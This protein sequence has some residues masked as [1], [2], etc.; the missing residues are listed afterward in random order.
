[1]VPVTPARD[2]RPQGVDCSPPGDSPGSPGR[3]AVEAGTLAA[4]VQSGT[5]HLERLHRRALSA[6]ENL[7]T[8]TRE[9]EELVRKTQDGASLGFKVGTRRVAIDELAK[10]NRGRAVEGVSGI[11]AAT[12]RAKHAMEKMQI[13][14]RDVKGF[15]AGCEAGNTTANEKAGMTWVASS[16]MAVYRT[17]RRKLS[18]Q[19]MRATHSALRTVPGMRTAAQRV[20]LRQVLASVDLFSKLSVEEIDRLAEVVGVDEFDDGDVI[21]TEGEPGEEFC[22]VLSGKVDIILGGRH[23]RRQQ[24]RQHSKTITSR[25]GDKRPNDMSCSSSAVSLRSQS[26]RDRS[27]RRNVKN[28]EPGVPRRSMTAEELKKWDG[29]TVGQLTD[30]AA[31]GELALLDSKGVRSAVRRV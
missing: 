15:L 26:V 8:R 4:R 28:D 1:M 11:M 17:P 10:T 20:S 5:K 2:G 21:M 24:A 13:S 19:E 30:G 31:F 12:T 16:T 3:W 6:R 18:E 23:A 14:N 9:Q 7:R 22:I 25:D 29:V 27:P